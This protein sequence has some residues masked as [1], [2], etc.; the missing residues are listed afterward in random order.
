[1]IKYVLDYSSQTS[2]SDVCTMLLF[3]YYMSYVCVC[4]KN[5]LKSKKE[6][7]YLQLLNT[8]ELSIINNGCQ[9]TGVAVWYT[10]TWSFFSSIWR[11]IL[12]KHRVFLSFSF[13][14]QKIHLLSYFTHNII[15]LALFFVYVTTYTITNRC[16]QT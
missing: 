7:R 11:R 13:K 14:V 16:R 5:G 3:A 10:K 8:H 6:N 12:P 15:I 4:K 2:F 9:P 1:M